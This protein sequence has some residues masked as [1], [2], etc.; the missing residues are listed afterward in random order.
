MGIYSVL[1]KTLRNHFQ[2]TDLLL[3]GPLVYQVASEHISDNK[4]VL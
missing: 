2:I 4:M 1:R 3:P